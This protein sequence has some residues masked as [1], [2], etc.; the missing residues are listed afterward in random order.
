MLSLAAGQSRVGS[1]QKSTD[2]RCYHLHRLKDTVTMAD[3]V[4]HSSKWQ[5]LGKSD[6]IFI[7]ESFIIVMVDATLSAYLCRTT[8][9]CQ[10]LGLI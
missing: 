2:G 10:S 1:L 6:T 3:L 8:V 7:V 9:V 5:V 4:T